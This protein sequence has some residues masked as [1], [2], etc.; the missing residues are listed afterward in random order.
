L[1]SSFPARTRSVPFSAAGRVQGG[2]ESVLSHDVFL[3]WTLGLGLILGLWGIC[4]ARLGPSSWRARWG[5][6]LFL[7][8]F[9]TLGAATF[10]AAL[11]RLDGLAPLGIL[12]GLLVVGM[13]WESPRSVARDDSLPE[14]AHSPTLPG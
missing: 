8:T 14:I 5:K 6:C 3:P 7:V 1:V 13:V 9:L 10:V 4:W 2:T 12:S 11:N